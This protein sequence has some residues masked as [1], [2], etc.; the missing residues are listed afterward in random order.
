M[1]YRPRSN[2]KYID[3]DGKL[4]KLREE[5][6]NYV[7]LHNE[8]NPTPGSPA[9]ISFRDAIADVDARIAELK[10]R[11][12]KGPAGVKLPK[13]KKILIRGRIS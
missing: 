9:D 11:P 13:N 10:P 6:A 2:P 8:M 1:G 7:F 5:R 12:P 3:R 4:R